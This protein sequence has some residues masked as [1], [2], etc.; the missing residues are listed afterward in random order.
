LSLVWDTDFTAQSRNKAYKNIQK[1]F[2]NS[3]SDQDG[4]PL[5]PPHSQAAGTL[6]LSRFLFP[7][8]K[9]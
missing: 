5:L 8:T 4:R 2:R 1:L 9:G 7:R 3:W 6:R